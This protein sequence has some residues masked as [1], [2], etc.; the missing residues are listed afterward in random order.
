M[1][2]KSTKQ[3]SFKEE[4]TAHEQT[5]QNKPRQKGAVVNGGIHRIPYLGE[6]RKRSVG[7]G[8]KT[9]RSSGLNKCIHCFFN[10]GLK[11]NER[12]NEAFSEK[13]MEENHVIP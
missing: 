2:L 12:I 11:R 1:W 6:S 13:R 7:Y 4:R 5:H 10:L 3:K 9:M 8:M